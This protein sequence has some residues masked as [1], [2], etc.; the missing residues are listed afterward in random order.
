MFLNEYFIISRPHESRKLPAS[1]CAQSG[2][3]EILTLEHFLNI[4]QYN[5]Y[6][7]HYNRDCLFELYMIRFGLLLFLK[8][9]VCKF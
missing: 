2:N 3:Y 1:A 4:T 8:N 9:E 5:I 7:I 6:Y